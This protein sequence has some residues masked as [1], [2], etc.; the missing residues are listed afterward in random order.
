MMSS[1]KLGK[2]EMPKKRKAE[3]EMDMDLAELD[4]PEEEADETVEVDEESMDL[5]ETTSPAADLSD[6]ELMAEIKKRGLM[7]QLEKGDSPEE[8]EQYI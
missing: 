7:G 5:D 4:M 2:L 3:E 1:K 8:D 6:D